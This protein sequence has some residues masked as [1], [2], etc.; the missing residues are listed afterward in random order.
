M[1]CFLPL[2]DGRMGGCA[3]MITQ[4]AQASMSTIKPPVE[5]GVSVLEG[6][7]RDIEI[8]ILCLWSKMGLLKKVCFGLRRRVAAHGTP[9]MRIEIL[10]SLVQLSSTPVLI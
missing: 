5:T 4:I 8:Q 3:M 2:T 10:D 6:Y 7:Q 1:P 9:R